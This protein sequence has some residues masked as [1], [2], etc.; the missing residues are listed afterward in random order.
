[1]QFIGEEA[2]PDYEYVGKQITQS[3]GLAREW[4]NIDMPKQVREE[5]GINKEQSNRK[6]EPR[7][8]AIQSHLEDDGYYEDRRDGWH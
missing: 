2:N 1:M 8:G 6:P 3:R 7:L 4:R 5:A